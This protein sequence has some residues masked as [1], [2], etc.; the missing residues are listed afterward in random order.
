MPLKI[1]IYIYKFKTVFMK[2]LPIILVFIFISC[3]KETI[4]N[5]KVEWDA[6]FTH[7]GF[8]EIICETYSVLD[9]SNT[10]LEYGKFT[11]Y[12]NGKFNQTGFTVFEKDMELKWISDST[13]L[14]LYHGDNE[15]YYVFKL[16]S[17]SF[18]EKKYRI[19]KFDIDVPSPCYIDFTEGESYLIL[20]KP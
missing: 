15:F 18:N 20:T 9:T 11:F 14:K 3:K 6:V 10:I 13:S 2:I 5:D 8:T 17:S 19:I 16:I 4:Q 7:D 12:N 1:Y